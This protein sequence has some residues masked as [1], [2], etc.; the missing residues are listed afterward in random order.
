MYNLHLMKRK[1]MLKN[2]KINPYQTYANQKLEEFNAT[3]IPIEAQRNILIGKDGKIEMIKE[4]DQP[5][6]VEEKMV[7]IKKD[8]VEPIQ[9]KDQPEPVE[10]KELV[11][12]APLQRDQ[13]Q[14]K[15]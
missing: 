6:S 2:L 14:M 5:T 1:K 11:V 8:I 9:S 7:E 15:W 4:Q 13:V 12:A 3:L 10:K